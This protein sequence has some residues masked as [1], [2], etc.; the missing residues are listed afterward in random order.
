[1]SPAILWICAVA[2]SGP[3]SA[4]VLP[5]RIGWPVACCA[6]AWPA[7]RPRPTSAAT[8]ARRDRMDAVMSCLLFVVDR[9]VDLCAGALDEV[10]P[11]DELGLVERNHLL[12]AHRPLLD[13]LP[14]QLR[15][16]LRLA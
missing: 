8:A 6:S 10:G 1:M 2:E 14:A 15:G 9:S 11:L 5:T 13:A 4:S 7:N 16:R 3:V 12:G